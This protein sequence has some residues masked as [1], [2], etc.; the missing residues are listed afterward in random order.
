ML[1]DDDFPEFNPL[2][3]WPNPIGANPDATYY[4]TSVDPNGIYRIWGKR[5]TIHLANIQLTGEYF[6]LGGTYAALANYDFRDLTIAADGSFEFLLSPEK[7]STWTGDWYPLTPDTRYLLLRQFAYDWLSEVEAQVRI[8]RVDR[9]RTYPIRRTAEQLQQ[10]MEEAAKVAVGVALAWGG[11]VTN[12][13]RKGL[14][15]S[16]A[17]ERFVEQGGWSVQM[18]YHGTFDI[19]PDEALIFET[20]IPDE[21]RYWNVQLTDELYVPVDYVH[22]QSHTNGF[23]AYVDD[24]RMYRAII[25]HQDPGIENWLDT[26]GRLRGSILGRWNEGRSQPLPRL[27][28]VPFA[29]AVGFFAPDTPKVNLLSRARSLDALSNAYLLRTHR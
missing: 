5:N 22:R 13:R 27:T 7:P 21:C 8:E 10:A 19:G 2:F 18:Y 3:H 6:G 20:E 1:N 24:A 14:I 12:L 4:H 11:H 28:K 16:L 29:Q 15:N 25:S 23:R 26:G 9:K 17:H